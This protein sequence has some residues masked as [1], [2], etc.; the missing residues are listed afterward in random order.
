[1]TFPYLGIYPIDVVTHMWNVN[2][3]FHGSKNTGLEIA[4]M[5]IYRGLVNI[6]LCSDKGIQ[7]SYKKNRYTLYVIHVEGSPSILSIVAQKIHWLKAT[8]TIS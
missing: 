2:P 3:A 7:N 6:M 1:M 4:E 8:F 5:S